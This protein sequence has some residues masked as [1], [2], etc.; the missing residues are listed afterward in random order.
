MGGDGIKLL[1][2]SLVC[3]VGMLELWFKTGINPVAFNE[4]LRF[5]HLHIQILSLCVNTV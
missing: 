3:L 2:Q 1:D 4:Q 5:L